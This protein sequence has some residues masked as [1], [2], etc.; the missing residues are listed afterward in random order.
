MSFYN[1]RGGERQPPLPASTQLNFSSTSTEGNTDTNPSLNSSL[2]PT[3]NTTDLPGI[4]HQIVSTQ[5]VREKLFIGL[6]RRF[7]HPIQPSPIRQKRHWNMYNATV[8]SALVRVPA[9]SRVRDFAARGKH[10]GVLGCRSGLD[11]SEILC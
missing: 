11:N 3:K 1:D 10:G 7:S 8:Y 6:L 9:M 4:G 2:Q 5:T